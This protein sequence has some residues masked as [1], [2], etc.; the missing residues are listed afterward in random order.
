MEEPPDLVSPDFRARNSEDL[1]EAMK[2]FEREQAQG[3]AQEENIRGAASKSTI[4]TLK[5]LQ[6][7]KK[8]GFTILV[9]T[10]CTR[11]KA[12]E[13]IKTMGFNH[14]IVEE[15]VSFVGEIWIL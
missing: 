8:P 13:V 9:E 2:I 6:N 1:V 15:A 11:N 7:Q 10:K 5:E 3:E 12:R 14:A 4:R